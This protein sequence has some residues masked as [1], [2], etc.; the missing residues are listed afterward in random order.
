MKRKK[1]PII[2]PIPYPR[3]KQTTLGAKTPIQQLAAC[4]VEHQERALNFEL[5]R[6]PT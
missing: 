4:L 5:E 6:F 3:P 2:D 1:L